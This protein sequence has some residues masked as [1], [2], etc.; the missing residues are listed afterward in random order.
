MTLWGDSAVVLDACVQAL[1][2]LDADVVVGAGHQELPRE[3]PANFLALDYARAR[4]WPG[5]PT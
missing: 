1:A 5:A 4:R 3:L 2:G